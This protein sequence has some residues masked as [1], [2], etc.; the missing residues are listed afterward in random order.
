LFN[1]RSTEM[2][3]MGNSLQ[4]SLLNPATLHGSTVPTEVA[5]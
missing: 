2:D 3:L 1:G 5:G 4:Y